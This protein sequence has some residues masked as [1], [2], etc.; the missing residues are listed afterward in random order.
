MAPIRRYLR[1]SKYSV[2]ECR[3]Y[4]DNPALAHSW[5]LNP[6]HQVL[7][8]IIESIRPLVLPKL[9]E[10]KERSK[11]KSSKK[12][13]VKDVV[14]GDDFDV[15]MFLTE[16]TTR[17]SL[18]TKKKHFRDKLPAR[19]QSNSN[20]LI[21]ESDQA[22]VDVDD[23]PVLREDSDDE[24]GPS[25]LADIPLAQPRSLRKRPN[26]STEENGSEEQPEDDAIEIDSDEEEPP[27]KRTRGLGDYGADEDEKKKLAMDI[28]YEGF[29][30]YG[31]VLCLVVRKR[32]NATQGNRKGNG[33][34]ANEKLDGQAKMENWITSTQ[35][36]AGEDMS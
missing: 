36:P 13:A 33:A 25:Q 15:S 8:R 16:T 34:A 32:D 27:H 9:L 24:V 23:V 11:K 28:S 17:H 21:A 22:P 35:V 20:K 2:L 6:R 4:L 5:L 26:R 14:T 18:L 1:I 31:R 7:P 29:A 30:I 19:M 12:K 3:I 10:E